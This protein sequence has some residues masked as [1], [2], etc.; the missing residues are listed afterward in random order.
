MGNWVIRE[1]EPQDAE[2]MIAYLT[3]AG[4]EADNLMYGEERGAALAEQVMAC[5]ERTRDSQN[6][7][8]LL[9][10]LDGE[11][12]AGAALEGYSDRR[13]CHRAKLFVSV[14]ASCRRRGIG[15]ALLDELIRQA[16]KADIRIIELVVLAGNR[17]AIDLYH[18]MGFWDLGVFEDFWYVN[19]RYEDAVFMCLNLKGG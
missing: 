9:G 1:A 4:E 19:G 12:V 17:A 14:K 15:T 10:L 6:S 18:K 11:M 3:L 5:I 2:K 16:R 13:M 8:I 7:V